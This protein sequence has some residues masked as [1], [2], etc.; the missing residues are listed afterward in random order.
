MEGEDSNEEREFSP[1][2]EPPYRW[3]NESYEDEDT[4]Q[5]ESDIGSPMEEEEEQSEN[6]LEKCLQLFSSETF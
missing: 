6:V 5:R 2:P 3:S 1:S 4:E